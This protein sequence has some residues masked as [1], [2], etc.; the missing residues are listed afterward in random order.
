MRSPRLIAIVYSGLRLF[1]KMVSFRELR[2]RLWLN[3]SLQSN[4]S[5][6]VKESTRGGPTST[7]RLFRPHVW[8]LFRTDATQVGGSQSFDPSF[9]VVDDDLRCAEKGINC[10]KGCLLGGT[11]C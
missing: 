5:D 11:S 1:I 4:R 8:L 3:R 6:L 9:K 7:G 2:Y 10:D